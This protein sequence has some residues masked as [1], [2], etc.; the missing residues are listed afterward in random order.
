MTKEERLQV[1]LQT[2]TFN[3]E[4][5][6]AEFGTAFLKKNNVFVGCQVN[7]FSFR[8][9]NDKPCYVFGKGL[10]QN[11]PYDIEGTVDVVLGEKGHYTFIGSCKR[12]N[13]TFE[14]LSEA[15]VKVDVD[16]ETLVV[17]S[18]ISLSNKSTYKIG[19]CCRLEFERSNVH[20]S[21]IEAEN[22][23]CVNIGKFNLGDF[24]GKI[25]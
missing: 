12:L 14:G 19:K 10:V 24:V 5:L 1:V 16:K 25:Q 13:I 17:V 23:C 22:M 18:G 20:F 7:G 2:E 3:I 9:T 4:R 6:K 11:Y 15:T 21:S 8:P